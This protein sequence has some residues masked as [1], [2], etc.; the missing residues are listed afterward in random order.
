[1]KQ[2]KPGFS[3]LSSSP[4]FMLFDKVGPV[5]IYFKSIVQGLVVTG[6]RRMIDLSF[7]KVIQIV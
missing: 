7:S 4:P 6:L 3:C 1:M 2:V 5:S